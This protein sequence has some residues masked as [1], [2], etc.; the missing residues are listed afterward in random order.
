MV[1]TIP[2]QT[3]RHS[4]N[5]NA[6]VWGRYHF[7]Q[8]YLERTNFHPE[9]KS[10][11]HDG[12]RENHCWANE[13]WA[14]QSQDDLRNFDAKTIHSIQ[15]QLGQRLSSVQLQDFL[16]QFSWS[17]GQHVLVGGAV[18]LW[19]KNLSGTSVFMPFA[20]RPTRKKTRTQAE[21]STLP[22]THAQTHTCAHTRTL[23]HARACMHTNACKHTRTV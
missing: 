11:Y 8:N 16:A 14:F 20:E 7:L 10:K 1:F 12:P 13:R 15:E 6:T 5:R 18:S 23:T 4:W 3:A 9:A 22:L 19:L 21:T 17:K 2:W